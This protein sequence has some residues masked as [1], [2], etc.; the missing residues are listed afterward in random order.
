MKQRTNKKNVVGAFL[1]ALQLRQKQESQR[2]TVI[3]PRRKNKPGAGRPRR[4]LPTTAFNFRIDN[5]LHEWANQNRGRKSMTQFLNDLIR[6][7]KESI[8]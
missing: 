2:E 7:K 8:Y 3:K 5:D 4:P 1:E 6:E